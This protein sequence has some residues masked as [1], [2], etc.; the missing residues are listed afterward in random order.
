MIA[1]AIRAILLAS[2]T[3]TTLKGFL[4][5]SFS[6]TSAA[7]RCVACGETAPHAHPRQAVCANSDCPS[8]KCARASA[9]RRR[10]LLGRQAEKGRELARA[11]ET[12]RILNGRSG[13]EAKSK[14]RGGAQGSD[15]LSF[16]AHINA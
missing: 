10:V 4:S 3:A 5:I 14:L 16:I 9:C 6:P 1:N 11:G 7:G 15:R 8:S 13:L 2:A 12:R